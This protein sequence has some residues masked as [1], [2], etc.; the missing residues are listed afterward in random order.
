M[1]LIFWS[2]AQSGD[3]GVPFWATV[4]AHFTEYAL[5]GALWLWALYPSVGRGAWPAAAAI[6]ITYAVSDELH[7]SYVPGRD[8]DPFDVLVDAAGIATALGLAY[9][10][11]RASTRPTQSRSSG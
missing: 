7:Q 2:S 9:A 10:R 4:V 6:A 1:G 11:G 8:S 3:G 5:L